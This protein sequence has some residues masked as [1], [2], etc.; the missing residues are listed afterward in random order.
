MLVWTNYYYGNDHLA[1]NLNYIF[2][3]LKCLPV[4]G[5]LE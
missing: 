3:K 2:L 1:P 5:A 4:L